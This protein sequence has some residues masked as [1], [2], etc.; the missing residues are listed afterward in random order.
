YGYRALSDNPMEKQAVAESFANS[1]HWG[2]EVAAED[3]GKVLVDGTPFFFQDA[4]G[5]SAAISHTKQGNYNLDPSRSAIYLPRT[6]NFPKNTEIEAT[7]TLKGDQ[8]GNYL[9]AVVPS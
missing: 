6:K 8:A 1:V 2:F 4:V 7:I 9:R 5:A 3:N